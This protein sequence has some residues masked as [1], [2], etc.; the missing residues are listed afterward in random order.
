MRRAVGYLRRMRGGAQAH[1]MRCVDAEGGSEYYVVKF[2][3]NPQHVR[4]LANELLATRLAARL[5]LPV[6][7]A[8]VIEVSPELISATAELAIQIGVQ[9]TPCRAGLQFGSRYP[10]EK[11]EL[12]VQDFLPDEQLG[13]V[14]NL[15]TF[16]GILALDKWLCNCN[17]RQAIFSR[18]G[19]EPRYRAQ[20][21]DFGFCFNA[22][23]WTFPDAPLRGL[24]P[25]HRVY[26]GVRGIESFDPWLERIEQPRM[27]GVLGEIAGGIPPAF[28]EDDHAG[29][30]RLLEQLDRRRKRVADLLAEAQKSDRNPFVSWESR[31]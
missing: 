21:I 18:T 15:E 29:L 19:Q 13:A 26:Q 20:F 6:P 17:G 4:V 12:A 10:G 5:G 7:P 31:R 16:A 8:E 3:N 30:E 24:Y 9:S 25:R 28:Y 14:S 27:A 11:A 1:L 22:G 2:Q 23:Q